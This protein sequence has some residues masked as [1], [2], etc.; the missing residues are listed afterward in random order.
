MA[1]ALSVAGAQALSMPVLGLGVVFALVA[2]A[3]RHD[4]PR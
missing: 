3:K 1:L 2:V 4:Y